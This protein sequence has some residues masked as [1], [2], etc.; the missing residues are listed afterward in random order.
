[1][2]PGKGHHEGHQARTQVEPKH[3]DAFVEMGWCWCRVVGGGG[4][5]KGGGVVVVGW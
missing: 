1:M 5:V 2:V 4:M 3:D